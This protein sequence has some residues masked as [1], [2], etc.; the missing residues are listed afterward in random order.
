MLVIPIAKSM[1]GHE[2]A[3]LSKLGIQWFA[4]TR[5][6]MNDDITDRTITWTTVGHRRLT[7]I[8]PQNPQLKADKICIM[9]LLTRGEAGKKP[10]M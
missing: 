4:K 8:R 10:F 1:I 3:E 7:S 9:G 2:L 6:A 5:N